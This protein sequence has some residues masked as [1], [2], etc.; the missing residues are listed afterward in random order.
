MSVAG[1]RGA[2]VDQAVLA[3]A[4]EELAEVGYAQLR[5]EQVAARVGVH[6]TTVYRRWPDKA[7][8]L[9][10]AV[11]QVA[12]EEFAIP[13]T[14]DID[15]DVRSALASRTGWLTGPYGRPLLR[16]LGSDAAQLPAVREAIAGIMAT[17]H[18]AI[19][20]RLDSATAAGQLPQ[21][22]DPTLLLKGL[23]APMYLHLLV[24]DE[25]FA[26]ADVNRA[27]AATLAAARA[28]LFNRGE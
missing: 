16:L 1:R 11:L 5:M 13:D 6:K 27:A 14:G 28:G 24:L 2:V 12:V 25:P 26:S 17:R 7:A 10:E 19:Q 9:S 23:I 4:L 15:S 3:G 20:I 22:V 18:D 21:R 8:L